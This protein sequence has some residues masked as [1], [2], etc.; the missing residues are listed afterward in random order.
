VASHAAAGLAGGALALALTFAGAAVFGWLPSGQTYPA[1][2]VDDLRRRVAA[3]EKRAADPPRD[4]QATELGRRLA[5]VEGRMARVDDIGRRLDAIA[6]AQTALD[7]RTRTLEDRIGQA[8]GASELADR[9]GRLEQTI[10]TLSAAAASDPQPGRIP[11]L[12]ALSG[13]LNDLETTLN[14]QLTALRK[15]VAQEVETRTSAAQEAGE[16]A[17]SATQRIDRE[18]SAL[19]AEAAR[20]AQRSEALKAADDSFQQGLRALQEETA[21]ARSALDALRTDL[22]AQLR[23]VTRPQDLNAALAPLAD[24]IAA[25]ERNVEGVLKN[26]EERKANAERVVLALEIGNLKRAVERG[27]KY[28][29]ELA[30]VKQMAGSTIDLSPLERYKEQGISTSSDLARDFRSVANA[31]L[32]AESAPAD[33]STLDRLLQGARSIVRVRRTDHRPDDM[34]TEAIIARME[35]AVGDD[36]LADVLAEASR[37]SPQARAPAEDWLARVEARVAADRALARIEEQLKASMSGKSQQ[38]KRT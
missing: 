31:M 15:S 4:A 13:K 10:A 23:G 1:N 6:D 11:Q 8:Q 5:D 14:N 37:L 24:K 2:V 22:A 29:R 38:D 36:R 18:L 12:A 17:R 28:S 20:L 35:R 3:L 26:E 27:A 16:A 32:D 25:M 33:S 9:L 7:G 30:A 21:A 34:R 19:K